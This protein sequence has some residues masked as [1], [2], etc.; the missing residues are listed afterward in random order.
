VS[1]PFNTSLRRGA[2][3]PRD[4]IARVDAEVRDR[5]GEA[6]DFVCLEAMVQA[7]REAGRPAPA[8]DSAD[9]RAEFDRR[10]DAFL[11][12][13]GES[14]MST[15][16][17]EQRRSL[18]AEQRPSLDAE[19]QRP[20]DAAGPGAQDRLARLVAVQ[21]G[22]AKLLPDYWQRFEQVRAAHAAEPDTPPP[23]GRDRPG[24]LDRIFRR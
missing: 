11:A 12:R 5:I 8:P 23:S 22:L 24:W 15:L 4:L 7:R 20:V 16:D 17:A 13:L 10:V 2:G 3:E 21:V 6:V 18:D 14:M 19:P 9:D 1:R